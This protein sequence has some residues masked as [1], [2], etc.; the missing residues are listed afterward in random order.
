[1]EIAFEEIESEFEQTFRYVKQDIAKILEKDLRLHYTIAL[2]A[3]CA[4]EML[5]WHQDSTED[6]VFT[7]LLPDS[8]KAVGKTLLDALR[9]GLAHNF[10]P[11]T[12]KFGNEK[13]RL[14][15][16]SEQGGPFLKVLEDE[17][18][19]QQRW[20]VLN[21]RTLSS[22]IFSLIDAYEE[23]LRTSAD[24]RLNFEQK[25]ERSIKSI[26]AEATR[27]AEAFRSLPQEA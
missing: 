11:K 10:R 24:A 25:S 21:V 18:E 3:C 20:I 16:Y 15:I 1:M 13:W 8:Y 27:L 5:A 4:C 23:R 19:Q 26:S 6:E 2:L 12:I 7:S 17:E 22:R 9:N 14:S